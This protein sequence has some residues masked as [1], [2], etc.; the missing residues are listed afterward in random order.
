VQSIK[1]LSFYPNRSR[2]VQRVKRVSGFT[3]IELIAGIVLVAIISSAVTSRWFGEES[4]RVNAAAS[5]LV[6]VTRLAQKISLSHGGVDIHL[7]VARLVDGWQYRILE[8]DAGALTT[9]HQ[10]DVDGRDIDLSVTAG[11]GPS[12]VITGSDLD[13]EFDH[14]GNVSELFLGATPGAVTNGVAI[15]LSDSINFPICIS[16]LGFAHVGTCI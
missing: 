11:I 14:L 6:S 5:Q 15:Q 7:V 4:Y 10:F 9:L 13:I 1:G 3:F 16:P 8:D 2:F 12:S